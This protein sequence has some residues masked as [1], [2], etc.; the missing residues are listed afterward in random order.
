MVGAKLLG[1]RVRGA[2]RSWSRGGAS[3][4]GAD[5]R[6]RC[7]HQDSDAWVK[8]R[9]NVRERLTVQTAW[10]EKSYSLNDAERKQKGSSLN[11][12][13]S[14]STYCRCSSLNQSSVRLPF[15]ISSSDGT[16]L[17]FGRKK[18]TIQ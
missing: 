6:A 4:A 2:V 14:V 7:S 16:M 11:L 8:V 17:V 13:A 9:R 3:A 18:K 12:N 1:R 15:I 10:R 5:Y